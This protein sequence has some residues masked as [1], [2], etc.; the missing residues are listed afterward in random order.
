MADEATT[1][2]TTDEAVTAEPEAPQEGAEAADGTA[3]EVD[4][5]SLE[6]ID[7]SD[8]WDSERALKKI[9]KLNN[10]IRSAKAT[11]A[12]AK[13]RAEGMPDPNN[14]RIK[15]LEAENL[16][17]RIGAKHGLPEELINR[18]QGDTE[19][20]ILADAEKLLDLV[21]VRKAPPSRRPTE[22]LRGGTEP[23]TE[24]E[25]RDLDKLAS[26]MFRR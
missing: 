22:N 24:P 17:I 3:G 5:E 20:E 15:A 2:E 6:E 7:E 13:R 25:E 4:P 12:A 18:L 1:T 10:E 26:R 9:R 21:S 8:A 16:R 19:E 11:A 23:A 14:E